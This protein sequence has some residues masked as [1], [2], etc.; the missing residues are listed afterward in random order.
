MKYPFV[1]YR[2]MRR[3]GRTFG[4]VTFIQKGL[5]ADR[6][7]HAHEAAHRRWWATIGVLAAILIAIPVVLAGG[8]IGLAV[9]GLATHP[10]AY[11]FWHKYRERAEIHAMTVGI[12]AAVNQ[13]NIE[14]DIDRA[15]EA[16]GSHYKLRG[17][18]DYYR[19]LLRS[20][21]LGID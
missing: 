11:R 8:P 4:P 13:G 9:F 7:V 2:D 17:S 21:I 10:L 12:W 6:A 5:E 19:R 16:M 1:F 14:A 20:E 3:R 15:A 18:E